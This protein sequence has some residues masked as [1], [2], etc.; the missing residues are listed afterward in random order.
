MPLQNGIQYTIFYWIP[1]FAG[2]TNWK[3]PGLIQRFIKLD[4]NKQKSNIKFAGKRET[5]WT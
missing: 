1:A 5:E 2:M 3:Y 4:S